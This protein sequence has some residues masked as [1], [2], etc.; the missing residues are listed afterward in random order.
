MKI[1]MV[2]LLHMATI[3]NITGYPRERLRSIVMSM[4]VSLSVYPTG[5]LPDR[6]RDLYQFFVHIIHVRGSVLLQHVDDRPHRLSPGRGF[7]PHLKCIIDRKTGMG[8]HSA[9]EVCYLRLPSLSLR[10]D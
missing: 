8:V 2:S 7:L 4:S 5:Y 6:T 1:Y 3:N 10:V 9:G